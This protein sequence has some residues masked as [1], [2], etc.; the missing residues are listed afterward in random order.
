[1]KRIF[2]FVLALCLAICFCSCSDSSEPI[3]LAYGLQA[4]PT[5]LDPQ[6][7][8]SPSAFT[9]L[10]ATMEGLYRFDETGTPVLGVAEKE[11][12][13]SADQKNIRLPFGK[14]QS[15]HI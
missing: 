8:S 6:S 2:A 10:Y 1:M 15:G 11:P 7:A 4:N 12:E 13:I 9:V 3:V 14:M 5:N